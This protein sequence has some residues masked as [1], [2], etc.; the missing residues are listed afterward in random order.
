V[1]R[2]RNPGGRRPNSRQYRQASRNH[3]PPKISIFIKLDK[4]LSMFLRVVPDYAAILGLFYLLLS[5]SVIQAR[6][7]RK[8][9]LGTG[10]AHELERRIRVHGN[11]SEYVP[12]TLLLLAMADIRGAVFWLLHPLCICLL[13]GRLIHAWGLSRPPEVNGYR[14]VGMGLTFVALAGAAALLL[15]WII[16]AF[17]ASC[18][19]TL[20]RGGIRTRP[21]VPNAPASTTANQDGCRS[22]QPKGLAIPTRITRPF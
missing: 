21:I 16:G 19:C 13:A 12:L 18:A 2:S 22:P 10:G 7:R 17:A 3:I 1:S 9:S 15:S 6:R 4:G 8:V 5:I 20:A 14:V 11:F